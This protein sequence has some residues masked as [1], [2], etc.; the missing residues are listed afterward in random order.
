MNVFEKASRLKYRFESSK[1]QLTVEQL[2]DLP[3]K[4]TVGHVDLDTIARTVNSELKAVGEESFVATRPDPKRGELESKLELV[5][6]IIQTKL[7]ENAAKTAEAARQSQIAK[8]QEAL[9]RKKDAALE[10]MTVEDLEKQLA[11]L[12]AS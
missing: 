6:H 5:K 9:D 7:D 11:A 8:V 2:W 4:S 1:G 10:G 3:L 12:R